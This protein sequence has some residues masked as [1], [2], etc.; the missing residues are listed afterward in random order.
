MTLFSLLCNGWH[1]IT[2]FIILHFWDFT[3]VQQGD[4]SCLPRSAVR[5]YSGEPGK[6]YRHWQT[7]DWLIDDLSSRAGGGSCRSDVLGPHTARF[8]WLAVW[9]WILAVSKD[10]SE[11]TTS[12]HWTVL[13]TIIVCSDIQPA[14]RS[15]SQ[16]AEDWSAVSSPQWAQMKST[17]SLFQSNTHSIM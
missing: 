1:H 4:D 13:C 7:Y 6:A 14:W 9:G 5:S 11:R 3:R 16:N 2:L 15:A 8:A 12:I 10:N 17:D